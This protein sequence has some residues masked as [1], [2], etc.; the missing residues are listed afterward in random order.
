MSAHDGTSFRSEGNFG[1]NGIQRVWCSEGKH[2]MYATQIQTTVTPLER[3]RVGISIAITEGETAKITFTGLPDGDSD[4]K[5]LFEEPRTVKVSGGSF[6]DWFAPN[7]VH[8]YVIHR[9]L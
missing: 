4:A 5:V 1:T 3:N 8:V 7:D 6:T 9:N 2:G